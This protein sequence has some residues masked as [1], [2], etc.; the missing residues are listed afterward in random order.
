[1]K[2]ALKIERCEDE[3]N[4]I[5][6]GLHGFT[7]NDISGLHQN[8]RTRFYI[9]NIFVLMKDSPRVELFFSSGKFKK[10]H[11][12]STN[13]ENKLNR[14]VKSQRE[15]ETR[16]TALMVTVPV[17]FFPYTTYQQSG[18]LLDSWLK[19]SS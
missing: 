14:I 13:N 2:N 8:E 4:Q 10:F 5:K 17:I 11:I 12:S 7:F 19:G 6:P 16:L 1:M 9:L 3:G 18:K 15:F